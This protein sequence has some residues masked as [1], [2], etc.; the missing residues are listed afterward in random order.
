MEEYVVEKEFTHKQLKCVVIIGSTG[1]RCGY[2]GVGKNH[3]LYGKSYNDYLDIKKSEIQDKEISG[4]FPLFRAMLD[5]DERAKIEL[6]FN[7]HGGITYA[8]GG[9]NSKYPIKSDLW[10]F[11]FDCGHAGDA[12]DYKTV[13]ELFSEK[14]ILKRIEKLE[15]IDK[16]Y[17]IE[18]DS[19][20][21]AEY[22]A[23][24]CKK[25]ADQLAEF[26]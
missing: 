5:K 19:I 26:L 12:R 13:K 21:S 25:L 11:G 15:Q 20:R 17:P 22:V 23:E 6:Y 4:V 8:N 1:H 7:I 10:W 18:S 24:K 3:S 14:E 9:E 2:V 16:M